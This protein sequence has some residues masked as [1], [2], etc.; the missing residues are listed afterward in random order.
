MPGNN[1]VGEGSMT[2]LE[3]V[4]HKEIKIKLEFLKP[5][6]DTASTDFTFVPK[7]DKT[8]VTWSMYG[9]KDFL[10][11]VMGVIFDMEVMV[12]SKYEEGLANLKRVVE[13]KSPE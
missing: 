11:K 4:P 3:S 13:K 1:E 6:A 12:G 10:G 7:G 2:I 9:T 8:E 5:F